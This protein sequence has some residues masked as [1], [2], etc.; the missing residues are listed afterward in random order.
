LWALTDKY[1]K[2]RITLLSDDEIDILTHQYEDYDK[3]IERLLI[4]IKQMI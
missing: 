4:H 1:K 3:V 2:K